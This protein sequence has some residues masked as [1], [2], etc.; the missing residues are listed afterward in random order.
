MQL[1]TRQVGRTD[2]KITTLGLGCATLG[3]SM[4]SSTEADARMLILDA[5]DN[6]I[7]YFDT[8]PF[9]GYGKSEHVVGDVL[10]WH[11]GYVL[12]TK[13]GRLLKPRR[14]PQREGDQWKMPL[15][16]EPVFN[17][18]YDAIMRSYED[19]MQRMGL[20]KIDILYIHD[21]DTYSH[22]TKEKQEKAF[23]QAMDETY[24]ALDELRRA[25]EIKAIGLGVNEAA[26]IADALQHGQWDVFLLAGRYTL[27][28]QEPLHT[29]FPAVEKHGASIIVGGPFNSGVL[30]GREIWNYSKAPADVLAK[31]RRI[32][33]VCDAHNVPLAS[34]AL[35]FPLANPLVA[36]VIP[37]PHSAG[38]LNQILGWWQTPIPAALWSDLKS[39]GLLDAAAP[40]PT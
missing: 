9:Y 17:Y 3:G 29:L 7:R 33:D 37:G 32:A 5:F 26:P 40:V 31:V 20:N 4:E 25:G 36:N 16:F 21:I 1:E 27:L 2:L 39:A 28:E 34:A 14:E 19:S 18:S 38:E 8:A 13:V 30:V 15:P 35:Q 12:S 11:E 24:R 10:R 6:G 22:G 23:R